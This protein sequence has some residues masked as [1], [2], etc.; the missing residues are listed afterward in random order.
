MTVTTDERDFMLGELGP[1]VMKAA[2]AVARNWPGVIEDDDLEH[3]MLVRL[4]ETPNSVEKIYEMENKSRVQA[5]TWMGHQI[6]KGERTSFEHFSGNFRYSVNE[7]KKLL[8]GGMLRGMNP[9]TG[10][11]W[12]AEDYVATDG[13]FEDGL[14]NRYSTELDLVRA[15]VRLEDKNHEAA[16]AIVLRYLVG[17]VPK[18]SKDEM[19]LSRGLEYLTEEMNRSFKKQH[20]EAPDGPGTRKVF[21]NA[22]AR[23]ISANDYNGDQGE[24]RW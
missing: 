9:A 14:L 1:Q 12:A 16:R 4:L 24:G 3:D 13:S 10:S 19:T 2:K 23:G 21:S 20:A 7:V 18:G 11:S 22:S 8:A 6:A 15:M 17:R 5:L